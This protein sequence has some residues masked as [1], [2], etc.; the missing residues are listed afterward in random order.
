MPNK[1]TPVQTQV[2]AKG[3]HVQLVAE[4]AARQPTPAHQQ[5]S[6][7]VSITLSELL[8][9]TRF[10]AGCL[11]QSTTQSWLGVPEP[12]CLHLH[13][14]LRVLLRCRLSRHQSLKARDRFAAD[15]HKILD[16]ETGVLRDQLCVLLPLF[17]GRLW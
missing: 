9:S 13:Q 14:Q 8:G 1:Q 11:I 10:L 6:F 4:L 2:Q 17:P 15:R 7:E 3:A 12:G 5:S 16:L